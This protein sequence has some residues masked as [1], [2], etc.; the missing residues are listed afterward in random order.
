MGD[1]A[2]F[3][4]KVTCDE[5]WN[6]WYDAGLRVEIVDKSGNRMDVH[7][8]FQYWVGGVYN[9]ANYI[10]NGY[11]WATEGE[12]HSGTVVDWVA[13]VDDLGEVSGTYVIPEH[14]II[15]EVP[16]ED[17]QAWED[18][19]IDVCST[20]FDFDF[21][22]Y[23]DEEHTILI[24]SGDNHFYNVE[25]NVSTFYP[26]GFTPNSTLYLEI[27]K[28]GYITSYYPVVVQANEP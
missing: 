28:E 27:Y 20:Y 3:Y 17:Y 25:Y 12:W 7:G 9:G 1:N 11:I 15:Y 19:G 23:Q 24:T 22:V 16:I 8:D 2:P 13:I 4:V 6:E 14:P 18:G 26:D 21:N 10:Y 5:L